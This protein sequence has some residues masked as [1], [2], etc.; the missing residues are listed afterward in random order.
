MVNLSIDWAK[1]VAILV[2]TDK[3]ISKLVIEVKINQFIFKGENLMFILRDDQQ[4]NIKVLAVDAKGF[5]AFL[6]T[7]TYSSSNEAV[8]T[9]TNGLI[10]AVAPGT[11]II[12]VLADADMGEGVTQLAGMLDVTVVA[13]QAVSLAVTAVLAV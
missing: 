5:D 11:A 2:D 13:G 3:P 4:A 6:Q 12:N 7:V 9:V 1:R 10:T 8:A